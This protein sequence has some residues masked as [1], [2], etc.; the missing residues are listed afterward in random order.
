MRMLSGLL[1]VRALLL[2]LQKPVTRTQSNRRN[3]SSEAS[4]TPSSANAWLGST[5]TGRLACPAHDAATPTQPSSTRAHPATCSTPPPAA[6]ATPATTQRPPPRAPRARAAT[7]RT[8]P[9]ARASPA[10]PATRHLRVQRRLLRK[11]H[12]LRPV[13]GLRRE[14]QRDRALRLGVRSR[15]R[16]CQWSLGRV[17]SVEWGRCT[18]DAGPGNSAAAAAGECA[19][20]PTLGAPAALRP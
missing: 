2:Q 6:A 15:H 10:A 17:P 14:R 5:E 4:P 9:P 1:Q 7:P 19:A 3:A 18:A 8:T 20:T 13:Q 11:R 16:C 12:R